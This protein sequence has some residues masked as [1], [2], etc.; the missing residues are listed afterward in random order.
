MKIGIVTEYYYPTLGGIQEH[1]HHFAT[2]A[3]RFGHDVAIV[4][5]E[6]RDELASVA[7][8]ARL[9]RARPAARSR[10]PA[11][12]GWASPF[13]CCR[14]ARSA[15]PRRGPGL[16][17]R[18]RR[19]SCGP[20]GST[21]STSTRR[22]CRRCRCSRCGHRTPSTSGPSTACMGQSV[23]YGTLRPADPALRRSARRGDRRV[24]DGARG[25]SPLR[26][27]ALA[28]RAERRRRGDVRFRTAGVRNSTTAGRTCSTS[29][30]SIPATASI[31]SSRP[32]SACAARGR[33]R[34]SSWWATARCGAGTR[35]WCRRTCAPTR[36]SWASCPAPSG[37]RTTRPATCCSARRSAARSGS[38]CSRRWRPAARSSPRTRPGSGTSC[39]T[40]CRGSSS[41]STAIRPAPSWPSGRSRL[42]ADLR[43][44]RALRGGGAERPRRASTGRSSRRACSRFTT[45]S[46]RAGEARWRRPRRSALGA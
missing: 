25:H 15:A 33:T 37:A 21:C 6:V 7:T 41:T 44:A 20:S 13:R 3:R 30:A 43:L 16:S 22:S 10:G 32:G 27:G 24:G 11:S 38:S 12:S 42:L 46:G 36:T 29:V 19:R 40:A 31:G 4:T 14:A 17:R 1:V 39:A 34:A 5:P 18:R 28:R 2:A 45:S 23:L 9:R 8:E 26:P 35:R